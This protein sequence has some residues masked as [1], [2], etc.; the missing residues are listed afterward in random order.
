MSTKK[1]I[2]IVASC[3]LLSSC[4]EEQPFRKATYPVTGKVTVDGAAPGSAIQVFCENVAGMD[5]EHPTYS[6]TETREDGTF[7]I[8]TYEAGDGVPEGDYVITFVWQD[9]NLMARQYGGPDKL[10]KRYSDPK[11]SEF[12]ITVKDGVPTDMGEI[13]LTTQ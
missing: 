3:L 9:Y 11:T 5:S 12:K 13:K 8:A 2:L 1:L 6:Q 4:R 10:K 7:S